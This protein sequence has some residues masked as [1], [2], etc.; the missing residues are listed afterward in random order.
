MKYCDVLHIVIFDKA[1]RFF[2]KGNFK[3]NGQHT[4][5]VD[6]Q[7]YLGLDLTSSGRSFYAR[8]TLIKKG[9]TNKTFLN[10]PYYASNDACRAERR[11]APL[12]NKLLKTPFD[13]ATTN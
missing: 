5:I 2:D 12:E 3:C 13:Y 10:I 8:E 11:M 7:T 4:S 1:I 6:N 9:T